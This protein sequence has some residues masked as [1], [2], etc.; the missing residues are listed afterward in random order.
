SASA[1]FESFLRQYTEEKEL[2]E[3]VRLYV[4]ICQRQTAVRE[5]RPQT[6]EE[7]LY[8]ATLAINGGQYDEAIAQLCHVHDKEPNNDHALYMLAS[9]HAQRGECGAAVAYLERA[10]ALNPENRCLARHDPDLEPLRAN[11]RFR[12]A[13][14]TPPADGD[15]H[16][17]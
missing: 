5:T 8:A 7:R 14:M 9:A 11:D 15:G 4:R 6:V 10:I 12:T 1:H 16:V 13:V 17:A 3:R 2:Y